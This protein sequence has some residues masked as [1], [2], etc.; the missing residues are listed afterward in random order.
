MTYTLLPLPT[1]VEALCRDGAVGAQLQPLAFLA[2]IRREGGVSGPASL[3]RNPAS[4][5]LLFDILL[6]IPLGKIVGY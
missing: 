3:L 5:Q 1:N 6:F 2:D 4:A